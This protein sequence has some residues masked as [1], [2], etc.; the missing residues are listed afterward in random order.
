MRAYKFLLW[1]TVGQTQALD[2]MLRDHA[3]LYN[4]ALENRKGSYRNRGL[5]VRYAEQ[6]AQLKEI[7]AFD[8]QHQGRWSFSSQ[9]ATLRRLDKAMGAFFRRVKAAADQLADAQRRLVAF[10]RRAKAADRSRRH[11]AAAAKVS[12]CYRKIHRQRVD[13]HHKAA[14]D[15]VRNHDVIAH[16]KL[17]ITNMVR[18]PQPR[19]DSEI[20][21][22]FPPN[23]AAAKAGLNKSIH[24]AGWGVFLSI[25]AAK[26]ES[27]GRI[28]IAVDPRNAS[29]ACPSCGHVAAENRPKQAFFACVVCGRTAHADTVGALNIAQRAGLA[30]RQAHRPDEK[31]PRSRGGVVTCPIV[32]LQD[33]HGTTFGRSAWTAS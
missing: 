21:G 26:A 7:R 25:L 3:S 6:S 14:L 10:P 31:P 24:D 8:P 33:D 12:T 13:H 11:R 19:P 32:S 5:T 27:A 20:P 9:Q 18:A 4:G 22:G 2:E 16:E 23:G 1:P 30:R 17:N 29:R 28:L 15:L